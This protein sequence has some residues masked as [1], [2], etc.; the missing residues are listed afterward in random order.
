MQGEMES[1][2]QA[3]PFLKWAGGK[4]QL[5]AQYAE[6]LPTLSDLATYHEPFV[7]SGAVFFHARARAIIPGR[8]ILS[9]VNEHLM[10]TWRVVRDQP[11]ALAERAAELG[12]GHSEAQ[13][14]VERERFNSEQLDPLERAALVIYLNKA[15]FNG[16]Y[17][18]N[19]GGGFN[20]PVGRRSKGAGLGIP[21][22]D[23][24]AACARSLAGADLLAAPFTTVLDRARPGDFVYFDP[25]YMP[26]S[27]TAFFTDYACEGFGRAEQELLRDVA[28][29]LSERGVLVM[30]SNSGNFELLRLYDGFEVAHVSA[31][32]NINSKAD[33][34]G[35]VTEVVIRNYR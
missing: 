9:D 8:A 14:Y 7:G 28:V 21:S 31:R 19:R 3:R 1:A 5:L 27:D 16:L 33:A 2:T 23:H 4:T 13:F 17:R 15:G 6:L 11:A 18:V 29:Q 10:T 35:P 22:A 32:R 20:V 34:R 25:P 24:L 30:I 12:A 26:I